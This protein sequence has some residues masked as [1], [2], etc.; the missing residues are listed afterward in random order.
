[1]YEAISD[2]TFEDILYLLENNEDI[3]LRKFGYEEN[4]PSQVLS[5]NSMDSFRKLMSEN[6]L[7]LALRKT[8]R[9]IDGV[10]MVKKADYDSEHFGLGIGKLELAIFSP[11]TNPKNR[12]NVF[13]TMKSEATSQNLDVIFSRV[14]LH[15]FRI[16]QSLEKAGA[17]LTDVLLTFYIN[18]KDGIELVAPSSSGE[19][20]EANSRSAPELMEVARQIFKTDRFHADPNLPKNKSDEF[21][22]KWVLN[23][24]NRF[25]D[26]ILVAKKGDEILGFVTCKIQRVSNDYNYGVIDLIGVKNEHANKGIGFLLVAK[27]LEWFLNFTKSVYVGTQAIN[28]PAVR[29]YERTGFGQVYVESAL[30]LWARANRTYTTN[31]SSSAC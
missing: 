5:K 8:N 13:E 2:F 29:L 4:I 27:A 18:V 15:Q 1:M 6:I 25:D 20:V 30:H 24:L 16:I 28:L 22:A 10:V 26:K 11:D 9:T 14:G 17:I 23:S 21:Y 7:R 12:Q 3:V 31:Q 19:V